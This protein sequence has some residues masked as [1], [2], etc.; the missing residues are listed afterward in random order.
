MYIA[1][2]EYGK[3]AIFAKEGH[4]K[5]LAKECNDKPLAKDDNWAGNSNEPLATRANDHVRQ[6]RQ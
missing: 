5:P 2:G 6:A 1:K 4:N 3:K